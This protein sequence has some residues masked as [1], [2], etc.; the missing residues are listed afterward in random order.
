MARCAATDPAA[1]LVVPRLE[2]NMVG[3]GDIEENVPAHVEVSVDMWAW[4]LFEESF[5]GVRRAIE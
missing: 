3:G 1:A 5:V 2:M 4:S